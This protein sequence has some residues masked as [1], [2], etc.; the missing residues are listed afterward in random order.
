MF[1]ATTQAKMERADALAEERAAL[2][3]YMRNT[4]ITNELKFKEVRGRASWVGSRSAAC[5]KACIPF[6]LLATLL[7]HAQPGQVFSQFSRAAADCQG[8]GASTYVQLHM[9]TRN[10]YTSGERHTVWHL[11]FP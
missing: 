11:T 1:P 10:Q 8:P 2:T 3:N 7:R 9:D 5:L 6:E 4:L